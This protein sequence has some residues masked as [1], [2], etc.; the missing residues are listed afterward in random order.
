MQNVRGKNTGTPM[1]PWINRLLN[2]RRI[3]RVNKTAMTPV[4]SINQLDKFNPLG[5]TEFEI[6]LP[7]DPLRNT[8]HVPSDAV[9]K[10][11]DP[12]TEY[13]IYDQQAQLHTNK[14]R[15]GQHVDRKA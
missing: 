9:G 7:A 6:N 12:V 8:A 15:P 10:R 14:P 5:R 2:P 13:K 1:V 4:T 3:E 11:K